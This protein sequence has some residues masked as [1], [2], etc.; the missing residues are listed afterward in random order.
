MP[1]K[2]LTGKTVYELDSEDFEKLFCRRCKENGGCPKDPR[3]MK[4][5]QALID[6]GIWYQIGRP[7]L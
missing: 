6:S 7:C 1:A 4:V 3:T 5:C 2:D